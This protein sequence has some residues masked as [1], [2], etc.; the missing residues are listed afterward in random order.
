M[1]KPLYVTVVTMFF[2]LATL[3]QPKAIEGVAE[4]QGKNV[5]AAVI[6][7]PYPPET[8]ETALAEKLAERG[9][10]ANK[11][12]DY[13]L[14][15]SVP[16]GSGKNIFDVYIKT[17]RKS[18]K[19]KDASV[20]Y[21]VLAKPNE[22]VSARSAGDRHG[23]GDGKEFLNDF[24]PYLEDFNLKLEIMAQEDN[25]RKLEKK[26]SDLLSDSTDLSRKK[27]QL[28][29]KIM[30]NSTSLQQQAAELEKQRV[31]LEAAK[32]RRKS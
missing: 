30:L 4:I 18:R 16:V 29:E 20:V 26:Y 5:A 22:M 25:I 21:I 24:T 3:A 6:E 12:K 8:V 15:R 7:F 9:F 32:S 19:Q 14:Y 1:I 28:E 23:V 13:Q 2:S 17:E 27:L 10:K 11:A 31:A